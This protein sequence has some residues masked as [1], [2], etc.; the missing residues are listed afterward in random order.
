MDLPTRPFRFPVQWVNRPNAE[1]RGFSG[2]VVSGSIAPGEI[3]LVTGSG[4]SARLKEIVTFD[5]WLERAQEG[6]A[7]TLTFDDEIDIARGDLLA[8]PREPPEFVDQFAAHVI[9][10]SESRSSPAAPIC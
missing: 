4:R 7:V 3:V 10:M 6:D 2:T 8:A 5:G 1:F 9:W